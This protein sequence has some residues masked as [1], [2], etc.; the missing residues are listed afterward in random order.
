M[1]GSM[2]KAWPATS[3]LR[4]PGDDVGV[5]V[6]L[7][8]DAV[9]GA[10]DEPLAVA[11]VGDDVAGGGVDRPR[12]AVPTTAAAHRGRLGLVQHGVD[13]GELG[14]AARRCTRSG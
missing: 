2:E 13:L 12:T 5:L 4:L 14:R 9:A 11:G 3:G 8:A 7:D 10:V 1:P 6:L